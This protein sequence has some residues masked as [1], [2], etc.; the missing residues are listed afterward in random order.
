[1]CQ[2]GEG[3]KLSLTP[4]GVAPGTV[5]SCSSSS[6]LEAAL[7]VFS[8]NKNGFHMEGAGMI[9]AGILKSRV[10]KQMLKEYLNAIHQREEI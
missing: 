8:L 3:R 6:R 10:H 9:I 1:M 4:E 2:V 5:S 7:S